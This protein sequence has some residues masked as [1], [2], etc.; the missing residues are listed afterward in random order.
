MALI[1]C[2]PTQML[3]KQH[4][5]TL[6]CSMASPSLVHIESIATE[7]IRNFILKAV[8]E[9]Y[10]KTVYIN[11]KH[12]LDEYRKMDKTYSFV[13]KPKPAIAITP[14]INY[15]F[16]NNLH[17]DVQFGTDTV[18]NMSKLDTSFIKDYNNNKF[19][20]L[21]LK[22]VQLEYNIK[23]VVDSKSKQIDLF[24][25]LGVRMPVGSKRRFKIDLDYHIPLHIMVQ[26][27]YDTGHDIVNGDVLECTKFVS[28]LNSK[29]ELPILYKFRRI[30]GINE[31]FVRFRDF[32]ID[33]DLTD[34]L[35][36]DDGQNE[37]QTVS[38]FGIDWRIGVLIPAPKWYAYYSNTKHD[39]IAELTSERKENVLVSEIST[40][41]I[42]EINEKGWNNYLNIDYE[43]F[44]LE[45]I[46]EID[47]T[48]L[49]DNIR[50]LPL[51]KQSLEMG[52]DPSVFIDIKTYNSD[53]EYKVNIDWDTFIGKY[54]SVFKGI[55]TYLAL[56][57]DSE[58]VHQQNIIRE[59]L[60][61]N[62][63][64]DTN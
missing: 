44:D 5:I 19:L 24:E 8:P 59:E 32:S 61:K 11:E 34:K 31:F 21:G 22:L 15:D 13:S 4:D 54:D 41:T 33:L 53:K 40:I 49:F 62:R 64:V 46:P 6:N 2:N 56:Y 51:I 48:E 28:Y 29:S 55:T 63:I 60:N 36:L 45:K 30:N 23:I 58:F 16:D 25:R 20:A 1:A 57:I 3:R 18:M 52:I 47:F 38:R 9:D 10:F 37:G 17:N 42:P 7:Y 39:M 35:S 12:I 50:I 43:E 14:R 26:F 27:A